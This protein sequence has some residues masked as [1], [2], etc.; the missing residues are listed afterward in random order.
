[1]Q[2]EME[3]EIRQMAETCGFKNDILFLGYK[4]ILLNTYQNVICMCVHQYM[5]DFLMHW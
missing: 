5:K 3:N 4:K 2:G 1:M